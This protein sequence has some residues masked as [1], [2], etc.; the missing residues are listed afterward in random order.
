MSVSKEKAAITEEKKNSKKAGKGNS[1]ITT[2]IV[3]AAVVVIVGVIA[4]IAIYQNR[5]APFNAIIVAVDDREITMR[6]FL[7]RL[8]ASDENSFSMLSTISQEQFLKIRAPEPPYNIKVTEEDI[9]QF[10]RELA[11]GSAEKIDEREFREW[12]RQRLNES[13]FSDAEFRDLLR[14]GLLTERMIEH[15]GET[16]PTVAEQVFINMIPLQDYSVAYE[17]K[18]RFEKGESFADLAKEYS[19]DPRLAENGG[20]VGWFPED[21]LERRLAYT[22]FSLEIGEF[23]DPLDLGEIG[24]ETPVV[25]MISER[26]PAREIDENALVAVKGRALENWYTRVFKEHDVRF[27][28]LDNTRGYDSETDA[29]VNWQLMRMK[30]GQEEGA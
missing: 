15:L 29:W 14:T 1:A 16:V 5:I 6:Y 8:A 28:G 2:I 13:G 18:Q 24:E 19:V 9:D 21:A 12:Y 4:G 25:I 11:K 23:S 3:S 27:H 26:D 20:K 22:A 17:V 30:R 7:K 10:A